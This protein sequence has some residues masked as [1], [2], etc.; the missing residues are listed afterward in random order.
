[1]LSSLARIL[2]GNADLPTAEWVKEQQK[3]ALF[4]PD[5]TLLEKRP[6]Q[7]LFEYGEAQPK[8]L[9]IDFLGYVAEEDIPE[10][11]SSTSIL[12]LPYDSATGSSGPAHQACEYGVPIVSA[13]I[14]DLREMV[15][16][17]NMAVSF[18]AK[19]DSG[20]LARELTTILQSPDL[21]RS[22]AEHNFAAGVQMT[23][24]NVVRSYLRWFDL[25]KCQSD[26]V[27]GASV[28]WID[29]I[30]SLVPRA[31]KKSPANSFA[32]E[33]MAHWYRTEHSGSRGL[34]PDFA[35]PLTWHTSET[36]ADLPERDR[37]AASPGLES[38]L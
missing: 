6:Y 19:G 5:I 13:D 27:R 8:H 28:P 12:V 15:T 17:E 33:G 24:G 14:A 30:Q 37:Y 10:L 38:E 1:M 36:L 35:N 2:S 25:K 18:F 21:Q 29:R 22:M 26:I 32:G 23:M 20:H 31:L 16:D 11:F 7:W 4:T 3:K 9:P 34:S